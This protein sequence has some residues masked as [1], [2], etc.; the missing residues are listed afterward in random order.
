MAHHLNGSDILLL[1]NI[2]M[3]DVQPDV[4]EVGRRLAHL[5]KD[6]ASL[7]Y[8]TL[9]CEDTTCIRS[10]SVLGHNLYT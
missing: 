3:R 2:D 9:V 4:T 8:V 1:F 5:G 7:V 6:V 10:S